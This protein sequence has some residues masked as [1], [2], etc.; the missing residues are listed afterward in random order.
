MTSPS[1]SGGWLFGSEGMYTGS[2][3][4][5]KRAIP[6]KSV[7]KHEFDDIGYKA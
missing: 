3:S 2:D 7:G 4:K 1:G 5:P 6:Q